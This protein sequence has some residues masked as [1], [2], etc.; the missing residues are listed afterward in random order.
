VVRYLLLGAG[1]LGIGVVTGL[2]V[3]SHAR[4]LSHRARGHLTTTMLIRC[5]LGQLWQSYEDGKAVG[6]YVWKPLNCAGAVG[7]ARR[8]QRPCRRGPRPILVSGSPL[9]HSA[10]PR[11]PS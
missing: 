5:G 2:S 8:V 3:A 4:G 1:S 7:E 11:L 10:D 6:T 9:V